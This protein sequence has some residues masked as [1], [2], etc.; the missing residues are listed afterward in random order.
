[1]LRLSCIVGFSL[2]VGAA[3]ADAP[4]MEK[5]GESELPAVIRSAGSELVVAVGWRDAAG[6]NL[7][8][9]WRRTDARR[10]NAR[11]QVDLW[12]G[13]AD[14]PKKLVR[15]V[16]DGIQGCE[17]DLVAEFVAPA[18]GLT[19]LDADGTAE[20]TF[21]YRTTCTSD[22]SP[23]TLKLLMLEQRAKYIVRGTTRVDVGGGERMGGEHQADAALKKVA[24]FHAHAESVWTKIV[25][26]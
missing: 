8:A 6:E 13:N 16:K 11:L 17:F 25:G 23:L 2:T 7:A 26:T 15:T 20:L 14:K 21:A 4:I 5:L 18:L 9:F 10:G 3:R 1:M 12:S 19:D 22:V 24:K